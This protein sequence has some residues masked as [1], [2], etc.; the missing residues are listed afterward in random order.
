AAEHGAARRFER[1]LRLARALDHSNVCRVYG[2]EREHKHLFFT[3]ELLSGVTLAERLRQGQGIPQPEAEAIAL[4]IFA[5]LGAA[6]RAGIIHRDLK[7]SNIMV[8]ADRGALRVVLMDFGLALQPG[9]GEP[10]LTASNAVIGTLDY[11]AP[12]QIESRTAS[13]RSDIYSLGLVLYEMFTGG[14]PVAAGSAKGP[15]G[16]W[17]NRN[18]RAPGRVAPQLVMRWENAILACLARDPAR[19]PASVAELERLLQSP[20]RGWVVRARNSVSRRAL[21]ASGAAAFS[22]V[23]LFIA[24]ERYFRERGKATGVTSLLFSGI[25]NATGDSR[26]DGISTLLRAQLAQSAQ[27]EVVPEERMR[28]VALRHAAQAAASGTLARSGRGYALSLKVEQLA[29]AASDARR[30]WETS[31][32]ASD[33]RCLMSRT[34]EGAVWIRRRAGEAENEI[35][36]Q[37]RLP[38]ELTTSRWEA[39]AAYTAG[40]R[41]RSSRLP[42]EA[43]ASFRE[44]IDLDPEFAAAQAGLADLLVGEHRY[45]EGYA[46]W[47]RGIAILNLRNLSN[48]ERFRIE[49]AYY[50]DTFAWPVA[51]E[52]YARWVARYPKDGAARY[53][54]AGMLAGTGQFDDA[55]VQFGESIRLTGCYGSRHR[56][57]RLSM[58]RGDDAAAHAQLESLRREG[59]ASC[60]LYNEAYFAFCGGDS[61]TALDKFQRLSDLPADAWSGASAYLQSCVLA[62][63]GEFGR[64]AE[65]LTAR[66]RSGFGGPSL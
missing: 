55:T 58:L 50:E 31:F 23:S 39:L 21:L 27:F 53:R 13:V 59:P 16:R 57:L 25:V 17:L 45:A 63:R 19:R 28:E 14:R 7:P 2:L 51:A 42:A 29:G 35:L 15:V 10:A 52:T 61:D 26:F 18:S 47:Q 41:R 38:E 6:H 34:Q 12:E 40:L 60:T 64:A 43:I 9:A 46:A 20:V 24:A 3:M 49:G 36:Q 5:G 4:Q 48:R 32:D 62:E 54:L 30:H 11:M 37:N 1:E 65:V 22:G 56:L 44:A 66:I 33:A 8:S